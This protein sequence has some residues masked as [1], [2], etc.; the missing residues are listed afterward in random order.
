MIK[1]TLHGVGVPCRPLEFGE[2]HVWLTGDTFKAVLD[3]LRKFEDFTLIVD[4]D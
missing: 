4:D 2:A 1:L 3:E